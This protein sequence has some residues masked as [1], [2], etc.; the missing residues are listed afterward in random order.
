[1][2]ADPADDGE[3]KGMSGALRSPPK[4]YSYEPWM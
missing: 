3:P 2:A 1:L 4:P